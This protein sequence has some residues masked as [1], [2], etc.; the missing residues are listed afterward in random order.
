MLLYFVSFCTTKKSFTYVN[1][2][3]LGE[4]KGLGGQIVKFFG[5]FNLCQCMLE[6]FA[7]CMLFA[8][9]QT[10]KVLLRAAFDVYMFEASLYLHCNY[11]KKSFEVILMTIFY[12]KC[13]I[14][15]KIE[16]K[17][18][19]LALFLYLEN[20]QYFCLSRWNVDTLHSINLKQ[21]ISLN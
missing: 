15:L 5:P 4:N 12:P 17:I 10:N 19:Y 18:G 13:S 9:V 11:V 8:N 20:N 2:Y 6:N 14:F 3:S 1:R 16:E 7:R 21:Y